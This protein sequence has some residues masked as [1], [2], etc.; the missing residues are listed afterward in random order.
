MLI[1]GSGI[2][3][4]LGNKG[5]SRFDYHPLMSC[6]RPFCVKQTGQAARVVK[7][8]NTQHLECCDFRGLVGSTPA[9]GTRSYF[10]IRL[11][12]RERSTLRLNIGVNDMAV[13]P[14]FHSILQNVYHNNSGCT[15][16]NNIERVNLRSGTGG[17]PL[18]QHCRRLA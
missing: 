7:L 8:V 15:E 18:C 6:L 13:V 3:K 17:K 1:K 2:A 10:L 12:Q 16:G 4:A 9:S 14:A 11:H 5:V